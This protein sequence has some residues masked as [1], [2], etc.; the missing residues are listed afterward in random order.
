M[1]EI[2]KRIASA[3]KPTERKALARELSRQVQKVEQL[4]NKAC[5]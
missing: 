3:D 4:T 1:Q 5:A 2:A